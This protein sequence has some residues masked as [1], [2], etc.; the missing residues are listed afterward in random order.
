MIC[1]GSISTPPTPHSV[2]HQELPRQDAHPGG[3]P[4]EAGAQELSC[5]Q[6]PLPPA[7]R[8]ASEHCSKT[9]H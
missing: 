7:P 5:S 9:G 8:F 1:P 3:L 4:R 2:M 6:G